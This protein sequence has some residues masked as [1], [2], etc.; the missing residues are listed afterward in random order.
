MGMVYVFSF[1]ILISSIYLN[2]IKLKLDRYTIRLIHG[3]DSYE[4]QNTGN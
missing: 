3:E 1:L 4:I 2:G